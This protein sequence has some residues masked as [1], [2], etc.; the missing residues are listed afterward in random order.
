[1]TERFAFYGISSNLITYLTGTLGQSTATA[2]ENVNTWSGTATMLPLL[3]GFVADG[4][5]GRYC[6]IIV[7]CIIYILVIALVFFTQL[8]IMLIIEMVRIIRNATI[9]FI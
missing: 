4:F 8:K 7:S 5:L 2:A 1:M 9:L 6:T 3:G